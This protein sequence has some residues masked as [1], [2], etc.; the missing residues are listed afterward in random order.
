MNQLRAL[1]E[2]LLKNET[3]LLSVSNPSAAQ[4]YVFGCIKHICKYLSECITLAQV[5]E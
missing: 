1:L 3:D 5:A 2:A 4:S